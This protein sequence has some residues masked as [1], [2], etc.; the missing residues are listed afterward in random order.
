[1]KIR[2]VTTGK[3]ALPIYKHKS[4]NRRKVLFNELSSYIFVIILIFFSLY[5]WIFIDLKNSL[6]PLWNEWARK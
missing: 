1:M 4:F 6:E 5:P 2:E 3:N